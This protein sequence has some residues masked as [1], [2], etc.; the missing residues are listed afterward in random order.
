MTVLP[1]RRRR[2][3][4]E[5]AKL[6]ELN[7]LMSDRGAVSF[8]EGPPYSIF[9]P[10]PWEG[11]ARSTSA[12]GGRSVSSMMRYTVGDK[13][14]R[15]V[16]LLE[17]CGHDAQIVKWGTATSWCTRW[18]TPTVKRPTTSGVIPCARRGP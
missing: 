4:V 2:Q 8:V 18:S 10:S 14:P 12:I 1:W 13:F 17:R 5:Q 16:D 11:I 15:T 3:L 7:R 9:I 6:D